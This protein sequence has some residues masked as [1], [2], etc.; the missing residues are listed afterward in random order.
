MMGAFGNVTPRSLVKISQFCGEADCL[1]VMAA[2]SS[3]TSHL[4]RIS[5][6]H[7]TQDRVPHFKVVVQ[8]SRLSFIHYTIITNLMH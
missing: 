6:L 3:E 7:I 2:G 8:I 4:Y 5:G 1:H